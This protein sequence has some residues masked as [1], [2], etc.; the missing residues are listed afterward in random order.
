M[1]TGDNAFAHISGGRQF[2]IFTQAPSTSE[3]AQ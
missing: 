1:H 2:F 3:A